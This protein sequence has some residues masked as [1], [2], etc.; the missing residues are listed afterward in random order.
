MLELKKSYIILM[1][2]DQATQMGLS[3]WLRSIN[4][5]DIIT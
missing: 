5:Y 1:E 3:E 4:G 2:S